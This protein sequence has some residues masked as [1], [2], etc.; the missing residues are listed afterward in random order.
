MVETTNRSALA[1]VAAGREIGLERQHEHPDWY[2]AP[3]QLSSSQNLIDAMKVDGEK[4]LP[5]D[6]L[7]GVLQRRRR[8]SSRNPTATVELPQA[9][10]CAAASSSA[11]ASAS[12]SAGA[13]AALCATSATSS[14]VGAASASAGT[15]RFRRHRFGVASVC[16]LQ[17]L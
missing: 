5:T 12:S 4:K 7:T 10:L 11:S 14:S 13:G 3:L 9:A 16:T 1:Q 17:R 15:L 2:V 8:W 6:Q